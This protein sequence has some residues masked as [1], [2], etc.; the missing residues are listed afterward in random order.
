MYSTPYSDAAAATAA[1]MAAYFPALA[2]DQPPFYTNTV[3]EERKCLH[4]TEYSYLSV[5]QARTLVYCRVQYFFTDIIQNK[6]KI[7]KN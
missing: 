6:K 7:K 2:A 5:R 4:H 1:G 3:S